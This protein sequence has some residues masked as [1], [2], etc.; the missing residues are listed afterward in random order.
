M[1]HHKSLR[2]DCPALEKVRAGYE[3]EVLVWTDC[4][5]NRG[6]HTKDI[7]V[8]EDISVIHDVVI[9]NLWADKDVSPHVVA[10][11]T[12]NIHQEVVAAD[13]IVAAEC[14]GAKRQIEASALPADAGHEIGTHLFAQLGLV[15]RVEVGDDRTIRLAEVISL[16][17]PPSS[18]KVE[19]HAFAEDNVGADAWVK[20]AFFGTHACI[21][22]TG[23]GRQKRAE[24]E[25]R[26]ALLGGGKLGEEQETENG[27]EQH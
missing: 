13:K 19:A 22:V 15:H 7:V 23:S 8:A 17:S 14:A 26:I 5:S 2:T 4:V 25:H 9:M 6:A 18:L 12:A 27:C 1:R 24:A 20:A 21:W 10:D 16:R 3:T 11:A